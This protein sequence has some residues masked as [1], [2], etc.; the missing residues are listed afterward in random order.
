MKILSVLKL[1][2]E[3]NTS[4]TN[5]TLA[6][7]GGTKATGKNYD[8][9][10]VGKSQPYKTTE[11]ET[12]YAKV[13]P[14]LANIVKKIKSTPNSNDIIL[15]GKALAELNELLKGYRPKKTAEGDYS[16]PFGDNVRMKKNGNIVAIGYNN[17]QPSAPKT[18]KAIDQSLAH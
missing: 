11:Y 15:N 3:Y 7:K 6:A 9:M 14:T 8:N 10:I 13:F 17:T 2:N 1:L 18:V 16:L 5:A 4:G 12:K